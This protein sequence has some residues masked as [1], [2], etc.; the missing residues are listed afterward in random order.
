MPAYVLGGSGRVELPRRVLAVTVEAAGVCVDVQAVGAADSLAVHPRPGL[1]I[2]PRVDR[3]TEIVALPGA[4]IATFPQG[5]VL[6]VTIGVDSAQDP[7]PD[8]AELK[9]IDVSGLHRAELAT[10]APVDDRLEVS[11]RKTEADVAL[12]PLAARARSAAR[13]LLRVDQLPAGERVAIDIDVDT[14]ISMLGRIEDGSVKAVV[15]ILAGIS[16]VVGDD[17]ALQINLVGRSVVPVPLSGP[18][19]GVADAADRLQAELDRASLGLGFDSTQGWREQRGVRHVVFTVT[20]A[21]PADYA[22]ALAME[23]AHIVHH[24]VALTP[25]LS[26]R[27]PSGA[28]VTVV[29]PPGCGTADAL[30]TSPSELSRVV[31]SLLADVT[32]AD[33]W[34]GALP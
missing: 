19:G 17:D 1:M 15:D 23:G 7:D 24:L 2:L 3:P 28:A 31:E 29:P 11:A 25:T 21:V 18:A 20:D 22:L 5:T 27:V 14:T 33:G 34:G 30:S 8:R 16:T 6:Q 9:P 13:S 26:G 4:G 12:S 32:A 10:I